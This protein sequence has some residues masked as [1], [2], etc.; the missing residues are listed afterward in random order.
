MQS[1]R[2]ICKFVIFI[3]RILIYFVGQVRVPA[4]GAPTQIT[5]P[6]QPGTQ[7]FLAPFLVDNNREHN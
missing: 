7:H 2:L 6:Q 4:R 3:F 5:I 1:F